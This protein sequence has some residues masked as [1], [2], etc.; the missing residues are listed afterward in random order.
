[1]NL[2]LDQQKLGSFLGTLFRKRSPRHRYNT[3]CVAVAQPDAAKLSRRDALG[4]LSATPLWLASKDAAAAAA[5]TA[6][7]SR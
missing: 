6:G 1:M 2:Q 3:R 7:Q 4:L 5:P